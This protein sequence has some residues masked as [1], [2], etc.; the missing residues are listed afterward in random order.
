[1]KANNLRQTLS[2]T[3]AATLLAAVAAGSAHAFVQADLDKVL[4]TKIC[5]SPCDLSSAPLSGKDLT[6]SLLT[7]ANLTSAN[8]SGRSTKLDNANMVNANLS[9]ADV[10]NASFQNVNLTG[11]M[12][13]G[14][15]F[16]R[17]DFSGATW[18]DGRICAKGSVGTCAY[19]R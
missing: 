15:K 10:S 14:W 6:A 4:K 11:A 1:M 13:A 5:V 3:V 2:L 7:G 19:P 9:N 12:I 16:T 8:L 17:T 18:V